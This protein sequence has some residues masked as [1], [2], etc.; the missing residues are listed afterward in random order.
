M[1]KWARENTKASDKRKVAKERY[2]G[3][4]EEQ[5]SEEEKRKRSKGTA[6][7][8]SKWSDGCSFV[9]VSASN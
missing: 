1:R 9:V 5:S 8:S 7:V 4:E 2:E 6:R 3:H